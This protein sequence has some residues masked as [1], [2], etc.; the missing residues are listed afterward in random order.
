MAEGLGAGWRAAIDADLAERLGRRLPLARILFLPI[1]KRRP[2]V[3]RVANLAYGDAGRRN[4]LDLYHYR[5]R[6]QGAPVM[7][8]LHGGHYSGG[9][10]NSQSLPLLYRL[11]SQGW[12]CISANYRLRPGAQH[13]DHLIDLKKVIAWVREHAHEYGADPT[14]L[15]VAG[16][17]AGGHMA[18]LAALTQNDPAFQPGFENADTSVTGA[19]YL[20]GWYGP[21]FGQGPES[22]PLAHI[23]ADRR[24]SW[25]TATWTRWC[26]WRT[27]GTSPTSYAVPRPTRLSTQ[28]CAAATT[29]STSTTRS[30]SRR[31]STRSRA[32]PPGSDHESG[33][34]SPSGTAPGRMEAGRILLESVRV[35]GGWV[36]R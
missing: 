4:L 24:S 27:P 6:P 20:N 33:R 34:P 25:R 2:D 36:G 18:G 31:S 1:L 16:S 35:S 8:H 26:P 12:V 7:I 15:W 21:Y 9:H 19:I 29:P 3:R 23:T 17:S 11:A 30:A 32:S 28:S 13:P 5:S 14:T 22:S 10:K